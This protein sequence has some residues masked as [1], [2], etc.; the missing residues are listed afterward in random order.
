MTIAPIEP[1]AIPKSGWPECRA[2]WQL[3]PARAALL[4]HDMQQYF[5]QPFARGASPLDELLENVC[6]LRLA[7]RSGGVPV[8]FSAQPGEQSRDERGL[9]WDL[10]GPGIAASPDLDV[11]CSG[12][13]PEPHDLFLPKRRYSAFHSTGLAEL[14]RERQRDQL[15]ICGVYAHIGCLATALDGFMCGVRPFLV[16]D[17]TGDFTRE[18]HLIALRQVARTCG[19]VTTTAE[20]LSTLHVHIVRDRVAAVLESSAENIGIDD[21]LADHGVDSIRLMML[22]EHLE[23]DEQT[24]DFETVSA[25]RSIRALVDLLVRQEAR[26]C[27][28]KGAR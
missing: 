15:I 27:R 28:G 4:V 1:Y 2:P 9:L 20:L 11:L 21:D 23:L 18:D 10:W 26:R 6:A 12:L 22:F 3:E 24:A 25:T 19:V 13:R 5:L 8:I 14:L 16:A 17:A 7:A